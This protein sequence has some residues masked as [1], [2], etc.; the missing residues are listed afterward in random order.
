VQAPEPPSQQLQP[1]GCRR[2]TLR[3]RLATRLRYAVSRAKWALRRRRRL[4]AGAGGRRPDWPGGGEAGGVR[5]PRRPRPPAPAGATY[6]DP[7]TSSR[8]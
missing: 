7:A 1:A 2:A 5:E 8:T 6:V 3:E 4:P